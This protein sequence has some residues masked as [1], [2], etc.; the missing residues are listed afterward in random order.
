MSQNQVILEHLRAGKDLTPLQAFELCGTL[1]L[2]S[3][4]A[5][6]RA[7]GHPID[8]EL[9]QENGKTVGRYSL[10]KVAYG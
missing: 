4:V 7:A 1:A 2:H 10:M 3:R 5:E 9:V 8:C 6:L